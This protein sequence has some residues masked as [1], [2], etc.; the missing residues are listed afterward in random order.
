MLFLACP[1]LTST[2]L[3][4][5]LPAHLLGCLLVGSQAQVISVVQAAAPHDDDPMVVAARSAPFTVSF[6]G[7][8]N[9][10]ATAK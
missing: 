4:A 3:P 10:A 9:D 1:V 8:P 6:F 5:C 7:S 2:C